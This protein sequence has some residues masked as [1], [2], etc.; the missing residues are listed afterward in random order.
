MNSH[1]RDEEETV[2][3]SGFHHLIVRSL[4]QQ[5]MA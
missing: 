2:W 3:I 4:V 5:K 1:E